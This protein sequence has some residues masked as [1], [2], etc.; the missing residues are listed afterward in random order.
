MVRYDEKTRIEFMHISVFAWMMFFVASIAVNFWLDTNI[1]SF[2][3]G[4]LTGLLIEWFSALVDW[5][6][7]PRFRLPVSIDVLFVLAA[8]AVIGLIIFRYGQT[9][10]A[11]ARS[12]FYALGLLPALPIRALVKKVWSV[13]GDNRNILK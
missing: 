9:S 1:G 11:L 10:D 8:I 4:L 6:H 2:L 12:A 7:K 5:K 13:K 3:S